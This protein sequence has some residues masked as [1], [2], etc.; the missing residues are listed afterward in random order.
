[1]APRR[2][3]QSPLNSR[4]AR[5]R[6]ERGLYQ[7]DLAPAI[8]ISTTSLKR[9]ERADDVT[10]PL[11]WYTNAAIALNVDLDELLGPAKAEWFPRRRP[12]PPEDDFL[13]ARDDKA[14]RWREEEGLNPPATAGW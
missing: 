4:I 1:M 7:H 11:W 8:G 2:R 5:L 10:R 14:I 13:A 6:V 12:L 9:W 3:Q